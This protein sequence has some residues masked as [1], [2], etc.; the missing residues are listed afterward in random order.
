MFLDKKRYSKRVLE[1]CG[2]CF[3]NCIT[4]FRLNDSNIVVII[5]TVGLHPILFK[6]FLWIPKHVLGQINF[7]LWQKTWE[8]SNIR[9]GHSHL[10]RQLEY[11]K[12]L[13]G[14]NS[15]PP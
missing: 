1:K 4:S 14:D 9:L 3:T 11:L 15:T 2:N 13:K 5:A 10:G 12:L 7:D 6:P 8:F